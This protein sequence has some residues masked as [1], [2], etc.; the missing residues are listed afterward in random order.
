MHGRSARVK[1]R[2]DEPGQNLNKM[3]SL[4]F[5]VSNHKEKKKHADPESSTPV[6]PFYSP[7]QYFEY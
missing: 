7:Q 3:L 4:V 5:I 2:P 6:E 1:I